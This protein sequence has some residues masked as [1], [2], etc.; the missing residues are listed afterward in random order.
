MLCMRCAC[1]RGQDSCVC[2]TVACCFHALAS[3]ARGAAV[4]WYQLRHH[5]FLSRMQ[6]PFVERLSH[7]VGLCHSFLGQ[8]PCAPVAS[9]NDTQLALCVLQVVIILTVRFLPMPAIMPIERLLVR[10]IDGVPNFYQVWVRGFGHTCE[11][12]YSARSFL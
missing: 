6:W 3:H 12:T 10:S 11:C 9:Q 5:P 4:M 7:A 8:L 2:R 1:Q